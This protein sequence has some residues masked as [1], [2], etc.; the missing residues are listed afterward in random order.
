MLLKGQIRLSETSDECDAVDES[1]PLVSIP[2]GSVTVLY[3]YY[4][5][6]E[7]QVRAWK[8]KTTT[9]DG[10]ET[11][12]LKEHSKWFEVVSCDSG[13][14][15]QKSLSASQRLPRKQGQGIIKDLPILVCRHA[16]QWIFAAQSKSQ[17]K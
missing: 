12:L 5:N 4:S 3:L 6:H 10:E 1:D 8:K 2:R 15:S 16:G 9:E 11:S 7:G 17:L 13:I 14:L